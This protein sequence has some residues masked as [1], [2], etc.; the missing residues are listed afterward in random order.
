MAELFAIP[1]AKITVGPGYQVPFARAIRKEGGIATGAVG[2]ITDAR[3]AND[4]I[5]EGSADAGRTP[6]HHSHH[7]FSRTVT[8]SIFLR[9]SSIF[10]PVSSARFFASPSLRC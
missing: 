3:Q 7:F 8:R 2:M 4:I 1:G 5:G 10:H 6:D 9:T